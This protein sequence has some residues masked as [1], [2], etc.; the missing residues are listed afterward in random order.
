MI[1]L[2]NYAKKK[3][4]VI[5][6]GLTG[7]SV[8]K[9]LK[10]SGVTVYA[11]DDNNSIVDKVG[12][13]LDEMGVNLVNPSQYKW[14]E[15]DCLILS[16]GIPFKYPKPHIGVIMAQRAGC[17]IYS[18]VDLLYESLPNA[19]FIG[20]TGTNGKST[21][22]SLI[23]HVLKSNG[24]NVCIGGNIGKAVLDLP[25]TA[26][27][28][29][30]EL[31]SYQLDLC[32]KVNFDV[33]VLLS[34]TPDH[35][36]RHG[37][38]NNY[39][40]VKKKIFGDLT[41]IGC[42]GLVNQKLLSCF[43]GS[44]LKFNTSGVASSGISYVDNKIYQNSIFECN[45]D[46]GDLVSEN[47]AAAYSVCSSLNVLSTKEIVS[48]IENFEGLEHRM[49]FVRT[50][51]QVS[52]V[53]DS[54]AT[55]NTA[56][57]KALDKYKNIYWIVGG[58]EKS[59]GINNMNFQNV[60]KAFLIGEAQESFACIFDRCKKAY[61]KAFNLQDAINIAYAEAN[62]NEEDSVILLSPACSSF[63]QWESFQERGRF[64]KRFVG[65]L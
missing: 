32:S 3:I 23:H 45:L 28:Y 56:A 4:A 35:L 19:K 31:S 65:R 43:A 17:P 29:V 55:N 5:G 58:R 47:I 30:L 41:V 51:S 13:N 64:F 60:R 62:A 49:E 44:Y 7:L 59:S 63:D 42:D 6:L 16:P 36:E 9:A 20:V 48:A 34:I 26:D 61:I 38:F 37:S 27:I 33:G 53:N 40:D 21:T 50:I 39:V 2:P 18:D 52:F 10:R 22:A 57:Q 11:W 12:V 25:G 54:K 24:L 1:L 46:S 8:V 14:D 15:I